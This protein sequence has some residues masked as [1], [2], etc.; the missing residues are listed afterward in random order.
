MIYNKDGY[1]SWLIDYLNPDKKLVR[2]VEYKMIERSPFDNGRTLI[3]KAD[4][5]REEYL[6]P[7]E[8]HKLIDASLSTC[9]IL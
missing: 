8:I 1:P 2:P 4:N 9:N 3:L 7:E 5:V 6:T